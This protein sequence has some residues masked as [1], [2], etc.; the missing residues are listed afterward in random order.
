MH[1]LDPESLIAGSSPPARGTL[2]I[3]TKVYLLYRFIPARAGNTEEPV[4]GWARLP[5]HPRP[6]GEHFA[7]STWVA[8]LSPVHPRPRGEHVRASRSHQGYGSSPPARGTRVLD[9]IGR[10]LAKP[11]HPRPRGEHLTDDH[12]VRRCTVHPR[13]RGEHRIR[14]IDNR[15]GG[16]P[17]PR[18]EHIAGS[19]A[20]SLSVHPR[21]RGEHIRGIVARRTSAPVHPRPRGEHG[22]TAPRF[23]VLPG[24]NTCFF[25]TGGSSP[26]ARGNTGLVTVIPAR[27]GVL[28]PCRF[29]PARA[30]NTQHSRQSII[31]SPV[32]PRPRG[33]HIASVPLPIRCAGSSPPARG[34]PADEI[35]AGCRFGE[36][37]NPGSSPPARGTPSN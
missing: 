30:G 13:P 37:S 5:V 31:G 11:V 9:T 8:K 19:I 22:A 16:H 21:P 32:H 12:R 20:N 23:T 7:P 2:L 35:V 1:P 10:W 33:E 18:G 28:E 17:R 14:A 27:A 26:P 36:R 25:L 3:D 15:I 29:I 4:R 34:T 24:S 6:R